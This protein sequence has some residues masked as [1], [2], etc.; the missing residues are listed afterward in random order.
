MILNESN[1]AGVVTQDPAR[2]IERFAS[3][4]S[5]TPETI[6]DIFS[7]GVVAF[8]AYGRLPAD[9][10]PVLEYILQKS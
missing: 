3:R 9:A 7:A 5:L 8:K 10:S 1:N 4:Y 2:M 6:S